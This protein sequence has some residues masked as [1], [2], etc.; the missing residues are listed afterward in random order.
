MQSIKYFRAIFLLALIFSHSLVFSQIISNEAFFNGNH[1]EVGVNEFGTYGTTGYAPASY[2][3]RVSSSG[4]AR[5]LGF[6]ADPDKDGFTVG[7][8]NYYG[9]FFYPGDPQEGFSIQ[10]N[11][12]VHHNWTANIN[13][14]FGT[15]ISIATV[16]TNKVSIWEG[17]INGL[18]VKQKTIVPIDDVYFVIRVE[19]QNTTAVP[20]SNV[21]YVRTLD[22]DNEVTLSDDYTTTNVIVYKLP[23]ANNNTLVS[24]TGLSYP[25]C[26]LG[27]G[28]RD[29]RAKPFI[30]NLGLRPNSTDLI[31]VIHNQTNNSDYTYTGQNIA[32]C[33]IGV[34]FFLGNIAP[35]ETKRFALAYILKQSDLQIALAQTLPEVKINT[36]TLTNATSYTFC[37]NEVVN[38]SVLN[39]EDNTWH[40]EPEALF[41]NPY[42]EN[43]TFTV[44]N[45]A[46]TF[47]VTGLSDCVPVSYTFTVNPAVYQSP[48]TE[49]NHVLCTGSSTSYNPLAAVTTPTSTINWYDAA[50]G[51]TLLS[52]SPTFTTPV[53]TNSSSTEVVYTYYYQETNINGC[54]SERIPF[55]VTVYNVL[56]LD[57]LELKLCTVG[58][59]IG[60]FNLTDIETIDNATYTYYLS[61]ADLS[62]NIPITGVTNFNNTVNN[63]VIF[64]KV[65]VNGTCSD[66]IQL[67][68]R[69]F[70]QLTVAT[71]TI[72]GCD[73]DFDDT[74]LFDLTTA[75]TTLYAGTD[76]QFA[77]YLTQANANDNVN[78][79]TNFLNYPNITN[80]QTI[81][82]RVYNANCYQ[83]TSLTLNVYDKPV[84]V[85]GTLTSCATN[86]DG[87]ANFNL[88]TANTQFNSVDATLVYTFYT[89][90]SNLTN[91]IPISPATSFQNTSNPQTVYVKATS[92]NG[93]FSTTELELNVNPVTRLSI[94]DF[95]QCDDDS[96]G[97]VSFN[98]G[99]KTTEIAALLPPDTYTYTYY[100]SETDAFNSLSPI[101]QNY[102]NISS[103]ET[104]YVRAQGLTGCPFIINFDLVVLTKPV[105]N[106]DE[107][108]NIC[109]GGTIT[110]DAGPGFDSYLWSTG[111]NTQTILVTNSGTFSVTVTYDYGTVTCSTS[112]TINVVKSSVATITS[113]V[114]NDWT[115]NQNVITVTVDGLGV[116]EYSLDNEVFQTSPVFEGLLSGIYTVYI[117][118]INECGTVFQQVYVLMHPKFF[119]PNG[120]GFNDVW[121]V[122]FSS[123][124][125]NM[126][127]KIYDRFG[128]IIT[129]FKGSDAG[130][131]GTYN[132]Q[133]LPS[134]DY[135]FV[136]TREDGKIFKG[137]FTMKR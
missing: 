67:T 91:N 83:V 126:N 2:H 57:N 100:I 46:T 25:N 98:L 85:A 12:A 34:S 30:I 132:G 122:R 88:T 53:L 102:T 59:T 21:Y 135:W 121:N 107:E 8:P 4:S 118:D 20:M 72:N 137:H 32:D 61:M 77:Y 14:T 123:F 6:V 36:Q 96:D 131:D 39:G 7:S 47:T 40:W 1:V 9:D 120:D 19:L 29:C 80:P 13:E 52:S 75:N 58:S 49:I 104:I 113:I 79:I 18:S 65:E 103:P 114:V 99:N 73:D 76:S 133:F 27:L 84:V 134:T 124:E 86:L 26:Y 3:P 81:Y 105:L 108:R 56:A 87:T 95:L 82:V 51:G 15:N 110:L 28:T 136:V 111:Q 92:T 37:E 128:K 43:V 64:V 17:A 130:W 44:P 93:C 68:L 112:E 127:V 70:D 66:V 129:G 48:L 119:T 94:S 71:A 33:G 42:G 60:N 90:M 11:G 50:S 115:D 62:A 89:S 5:N 74:L 38:M 24:A 78:A 35:G 97:F 69:I 106:I 16:G 101:A 63:Q 55:I 54:V 23:N 125:P 109:D 45:V 22:P 116:Y 117:R 31:E 41:S 10:F